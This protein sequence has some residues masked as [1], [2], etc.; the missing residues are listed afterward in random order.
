L[1]GAGYGL[2]EGGALQ[3]RCRACEERTPEVVDT[4]IGEPLELEAEDPDGEVEELE[5]MSPV[6]RATFWLDQIDRC[7]RC[8]ACRQVCPM[9]DCPTC[10]YERDDSLWV[11]MGLGTLEKRAFHLGRAYHLAGRCI[12]CDEC[13]RVCPMDLPIRAL[14]RKLAEV[15]DEVFDFEAGKA[16][17][18]CPLHTVLEEGSSPAPESFSE[19]EGGGK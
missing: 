19:G 11:G 4:L 13:Q 9:C 14:N 6:E 10:L 5:G 3:R 8:Y 1:E 18:L 12:G 2:E 7:I 16:P 15:M 17:V